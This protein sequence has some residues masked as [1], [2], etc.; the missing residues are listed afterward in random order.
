MDNFSLPV[1]ASY[2]PEGAISFQK[3]SQVNLQEQLLLQMLSLTQQLQQV[4]AEVKELKDS[5]MASS[6]EATDEPAE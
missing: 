6:Q 1:G 5:L 3:T 4:H 2:T